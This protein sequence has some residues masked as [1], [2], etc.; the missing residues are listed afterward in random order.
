M[1][2]CFVSHEPPWEMHGKK[3]RL[4]INH[5]E[6]WATVMGGTCYCGPAFDMGYYNLDYD[7]FSAYDLVMVALREELVEIG[8]K[9]KKLSTTR[10]VVFLGAEMEA[11]TSGMPRDKQAKMVEL[12]N[13]ADAVA[14][15][16]NESIPF[17]KLLTTKPVDLVGLPFPLERVRKICPPVQK[18]E[19][20]ELG[21][22]MGAH[23]QR[24]RNGLVNVVALA[25]IGLPGTVDAWH[26]V[27]KE[28]VASMRAYLPIPPIRFRE[29]FGWQDYIT[30][31]NKSLLGLHLDYRNTWGRFPVDCA[32]VRMPC[33]AP[34]TLLTQ[35]ILFP[36]LCV[37]YYDIDG[38]RNLVHRLVSEPGFYEETVAYAESRLEF[39]TPERTMERLLNLLG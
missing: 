1:K 26:P 27:E 16:H 23:W 39:F 24:N 37:P 18:R 17:V 22:I 21:S 31:A 29:A 15:L 8:L 20:I 5:M 14:V 12:L 34:P 30:E 19:E 36:G 3:Y 4:E 28:Y 13:I 35:K 6:Y 10:V 25:E 32:G 9:I 11:F 2:F 33:V 38:A 7:H